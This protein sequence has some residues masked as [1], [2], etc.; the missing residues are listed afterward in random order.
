MLHE[1]QCCQKEKCT[2]QSQRLGQNIALEYF[3]IFILPNLSKT[4]KKTMNIAQRSHYVAG[5]IEV[6]EACM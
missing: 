4:G 2:L 1:L 5:N 6:A 3:T